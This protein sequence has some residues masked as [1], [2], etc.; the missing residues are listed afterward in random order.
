MVK[1]C[2]SALLAACMICVTAA[3]C[4]SVNESEDAYLSE[5]KVYTPPTE[6]EI[7]QAS[8]GLASMTKVE[9]TQRL[10]LWVNMATS[11]LCVKDKATGQTFFSNPS[12]IDED[13]RA[14]TDYKS[15][16][17]SQIVV[18]YYTLQNSPA[19][20][21]SYTHSY[22]LGQT[23]V[24]EVDGGVRVD[25][26]IGIAN[27]QK[28]YPQII[29][30]S[31][32]DKIL[33]KLDEDSAL[34]VEDSYRLI[35]IEELSDKALAE[36]KRK[37]TNI[38]KYDEVYELRAN[39]GA[40]IRK[41]LEKY[42]K[43]AGFSPE[44]AIA[45]QDALGYVNEDDNTPAFHIPVEYKLD[46]ENFTAEIL[47]ED[48][49]YVKGYAL[50]GVSLLPFFG[51]AGTDQKG[52]MIVPDGSG[53]LINLNRDLT[54]GSS[55]SCEIYG[56]DQG[57]Q[58]T[59]HN[60][61]QPAVMP[62]FGIKTE[63]AA[64]LGI[65]EQG[66]AAGK[67]NATISGA[68]SSQNQVNAVFCPKQGDYLSDLRD[69][70]AGK[71]LVFQ[72]V[73][74]KD[75]FRVRYH[76]FGA[77]TDY[78]ALATAYGE[79]LQNNGFIKPSGIEDF[80]FFTELVGA[81]DKRQTIMGI[82]R[83]VSTALTS[84]NEAADIIRQLNERGFSDLDVIYTGWANS[85]VKNSLFDRIKPLSSLGGKSDLR[86]L[87]DSAAE[88][89]A[90]IYPNAEFAYVYKDGAFDGFSAKRDAVRQIN[91]QI[92]SKDERY[93][94]TR[95]AIIGKPV[96]NYFVLSPNRI[97]DVI[98]SFFKAYQPYNNQAVALLSMGGYKSSAFN[99]KSPMSAP[100]G[101][102][103]IGEALR[104]HTDYATILATG[105]Q[106]ML[107]YADKLVN[108]P[109]TSSELS[110]FSETVPFF[111]IALK[112]R[113]SFAG[114]PLNI[115]GDYKRAVLTAAQSGASLYVK[116]MH[117]ENSVIY[118]S[119]SSDLYSLNYSIWIDEVTETY[120][121]Y[122]RLLADTIASS[123]IG[124]YQEGA[125]SRTEFDDGRTV[126]VNMGDEAAEMD[127]FSVPALEYVVVK[128]GAVL[129]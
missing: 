69:T 84:Y 18:E 3:A 58:Y 36:L 91:R 7:G 68:L 104:E 16:L 54:G 2:L 38:G 117:E 13:E 51:S 21:N 9:E 80:P 72:Q 109:M 64:M 114:E 37:Y 95:G 77:D 85:G 17:R 100:S 105:N 126:Y 56:S 71:Q 27:P 75:R 35:T 19:T 119:G 125:V 44:K 41:E 92:A 63:E 79:Y 30:K 45:E 93:L 11:E 60:Y 70:G 47:S 87:L 121:R 34:D 61:Q 98:S 22:L 127:G 115:A 32:M 113:I 12:G 83:Q 96:T 26:Q 65:V 59:G 43:E 118:N 42:F 129:D 94:S 120:T 5:E 99:E 86:A 67:I 110:I 6:E 39:L 48:I 15:V 97:P 116:W 57:L 46:G 103:A 123:I 74:N 112:G 128:G 33:S 73:S 122:Q 108:V 78:V 23:Q 62:V 50:T 53:A 29:R 4:A 90:T 31:E 24:K 40:R 66:E 55:Y 20:M 49:Q 111:Q 52:Y 101:L 102:T 76:L 89:G 8:L 106:A 88:Y 107:P 10:E 81:I 14:A 25:Y 28:A 82:P 124:F 1:K